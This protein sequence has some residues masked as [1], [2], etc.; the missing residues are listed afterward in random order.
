MSVVAARPLGLHAPHGW[1]CLSRYVFALA[2]TGLS[3]LVR[4]GAEDLL[5]GRIQ[6]A[7]MLL[8]VLVVAWYAGL[9]PALL[10]ATVGFVGL[11]VFVVSDVYHPVPDDADLLAAALFGGIA[12]LFALVASA[13][14]ERQ[15]ALSRSVADLSVALD[16]KRRLLEVRDAF[17][18]M[19]AHELRTPVT[20]ISGNARV[21]RRRARREGSDPDG[22]LDD[23]LGETERLHRIVEDLLIVN[24]GAHA[25]EVGLQ[26]VLLQHLVPAVIGSYHGSMGAEM[27]FPPD[28][29]PVSADPTLVEQAMRNLLSNAKRHA[30]PGV[31][32][33]ITALPGPEEVVLSVADDGPGLSASD[34]ERIFDLFWRADPAK[35]GVGVGLHVVRRLMESMGGSV[36]L[37]EGPGAV[38]RLAFAVHREPVDDPD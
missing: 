19:L 26:P 29:P 22:L 32:V 37:G 10:A 27:D 31:R 4:A 5:G 1:A 25:L 35:G 33:R 21:L 28:L 8:A 2:V 13:A 17:A 18:S 36:T 23:L 38:F 20:I 30:G 9:G 16:E 12:I 24:R 7:G 15:V 34:R 11:M 3:L 6:Y 14:R